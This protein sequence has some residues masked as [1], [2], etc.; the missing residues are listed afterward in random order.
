MR[1]ILAK[2][3]KVVTT[4]RKNKPIMQAVVTTF[5]HKQVAMRV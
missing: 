4:G 3:Q 2:L 5:H 1:G